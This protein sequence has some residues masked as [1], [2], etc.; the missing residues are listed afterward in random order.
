MDKN[1]LI[2]AE[3]LYQYILVHPELDD[4]VRDYDK[5]V[6]AFRHEFTSNMQAHECTDWAWRKAG[7]DPRLAH[8]AI[9]EKVKSSPPRKLNW[10]AT[11]YIDPK[12]IRK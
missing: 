3:K 5:P 6:N 9:A 11:Y 2:L 4:V 8:E 12:F 1:D 10:G 7:F